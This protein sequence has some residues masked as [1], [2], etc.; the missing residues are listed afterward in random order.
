MIPATPIDLPEGRKIYAQPLSDDVPCDVH[1]RPSKDLGD[2]ILRRA[3]LLAVVVCIDCVRRARAWHRSVIEPVEHPS[4]RTWRHPPLTL[5]RYF[6]N[7]RRFGPRV[8]QSGEYVDV[9]TTEYSMWRYGKEV[10]R[11]QGAR[12]PVDVAHLRV[13]ADHDA[14]T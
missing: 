5:A 11:V 13:S 3:R 6:A 8:V 1:D 12:H 9:V 4:W 7:A 14:T 10:V 2:W